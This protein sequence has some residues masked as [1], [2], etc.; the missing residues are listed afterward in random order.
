MKFVVSFFYAIDGGNTQ[1]WGYREFEH[2][3]WDTD[4]AA[5]WLQEQMNT[6]RVVITSI[7][8]VPE[9]PSTF[10]ESEK[11]ILLYSIDLFAK[12]LQ[13]DSAQHRL[14]DSL[15]DKVRGL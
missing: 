15:R 14:L 11:G 10:F 8:Q 4:T 7:F 9:A 3:T 12:G 5:I 1:G 2:P 13:V 6:D